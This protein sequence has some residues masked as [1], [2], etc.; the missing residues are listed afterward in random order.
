MATGTNTSASKIA[1]VVVIIPILIAAWYAAPWVLPVWR[2]QNV[3][4]EELAKNN[5]KDGYTKER[6]ETEFEMVVVYNPRLKSNS[7]PCPYQI[8]SC[9]PPLKDVYPEALDED[10][11][12]VRVS[13]VD[14]MNGR[15]GVSDLWIGH[16]PEERLFKIVGWRLPP[17][18][19]NGVTGG[20]AAGRQVVLFK[21]N[22]L[23]K[24]DLN[25]AIGIAQEAR[26]LQNDD[27]GDNR[28]DG[29]GP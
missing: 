7:D 22:S 4:F 18:S 27:D 1:T 26:T 11:L 9:K 24:I 20:R 10:K 3:D 21:G 16:N 14:D 28:F 29:W 6:L 25:E 17:G 15:L 5:A 8:Y 23:T 12:L 19:L 13:M 2:W